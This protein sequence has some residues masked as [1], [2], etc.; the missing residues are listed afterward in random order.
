MPFEVEFYWVD[1]EGIKH[2]KHVDKKSSRLIKNTYVSR[3]WV[4]K[5]PLDGRVLFALFS[6]KSGQVFEGQE[7]NIKPNS[8]NHVIIGDQGTDDNVI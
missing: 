7:F 1:F 8:T 5:S 2:L 3:P 6:N 4:F